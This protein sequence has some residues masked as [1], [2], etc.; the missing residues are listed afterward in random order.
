[1]TIYRHWTNKDCS[2]WTREYF[3]KVLLEVSGSNDR[4]SAEIAKVTSCE[5]DVSVSQRKGK[6]VTLF[7][8]A[9]KLRF[10]AMKKEG[11]EAI[12]GTISIPEVAYDTEPDEYVFNVDV[13]SE[14]ASTTFIRED[15]KAYLIPKLRRALSGFLPALIKEHGKDVF[16]EATSAASSPRSQ[17]PINGATIITNTI[18][19]PTTA[20][21]SKPSSAHKISTTKFTETIEFQASA[22]E[23]FKTF[24]DP[25]RIAAW[26][27]APPLF[28]PRVGGKY[29]F[30]GGNIV[31]EITKLEENKVLD[32]TWRIKA[33]PEGHYANLKFVFDEKID[34]T[35]LT[36]SFIDVPVGQEE[37]VRSNFVEYYTKPIMQ[38]TAR[39]ISKQ[40]TN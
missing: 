19:K 16:S 25:A 26:T 3:D 11:E 6:L 21:G 38:V 27:R 7:D 22:A 24:T 10:D 40:Y 36:A 2:A 4:S 20:T 29:A 18:Q 17:T 23:L 12:T 35:T 30:F 9:L 37:I 15:L 14:S 34:S 13:D 5:G 33:W 31:G 28:E 8:V 1:M 39:H 32:Q